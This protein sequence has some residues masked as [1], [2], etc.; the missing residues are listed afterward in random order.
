[1]AQWNQTDK[2]LQTKIV[3]WGP[4]LCG[5]TTNLKQIH[6]ITDPAGE[7][8]LISL[9]TA[10]DRT[11]FFDLLPLDLGKIFGHTLKIQVYTVPG[12]VRYDAT[13][14]IVLSGAD[15][16]VFV[17]DS[18]RGRGAENRAAWENLRTNLKAIGLDPVS[19]PAIV[20]YNKQDLAGCLTPREVEACLQSGRE[21]IIASALQGRGVLETFQCAILE[22]LKRLAT[23]SGRRRADDME[24]LENQ[25][26]RVFERYARSAEALAGSRVAPVITE[27]PVYEEAEPASAA[28]ALPTAA[29][30]PSV[31]P[32]P[33]VPSGYDDAPA[34]AP[35]PVPVPVPVPDHDA[36]PGPAPAT[37]PPPASTRRSG[38]VA[39]TTPTLLAPPAPWA[40]FAPEA[41][42]PVEPSD[43]SAR[44]LQGAPP[45]SPTTIHFLE[46]GAGED[47]LVRSLRATL[48]IAE[49]FGEMRE[50]KNRLARRIG[51][52]ESLQ[53]L[54]RE[55][56][57][58]RD[59]AS[60]LGGLVD[61]AV[62]I[63][64]ARAASILFRP[65]EGEPLRLEVA[66]GIENDPL[67]GVE[68][69][70]SHADEILNRGEAILLEVLP[71]PGGAITIETGPLRSALA[72]PLQPALR[73]AGL[74][75]AYAE[76][77]FTADDLRFLGL[78]AAHAAVC[79]DNAV[80]TERQTRYNDQLEAEV[81]ARTAELER[82]NEDLRE[83]DRMK[84][85]FLSSVSHEMKTPLTGILTGTE[86]LLSLRGDDESREFLSMVKIEALRLNDLVDR[87][88]RF[89]VLRRRAS[90][91]VPARVESFDLVS[92]TVM[93]LIDK[94]AMA[95]VEISMDLPQGM[96]V[97]EVE[98]DA[99]ALALRE[100]LDN[101]VKFSPRGGLVQVEAREKLIR[102]S[103][104]PRDEGSRYLVISIRDRGPGIATTDQTRIFEQFEQLGDLLTGKPEGLGLGLSIAREITRRQGGDLRVHSEPGA[105]S[106]FRIYIPVAEPFATGDVPAGTL[107]TAS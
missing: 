53:A 93:E 10:S 54:A 94:A 80:M 49:Q 82:A 52:L 8:R 7:N 104:S 40:V 18:Q 39:G 75:I 29:Q 42:A 71:V 20:Q 61:A 98:R 19:V 45:T 69:T 66:R 34:P 99:M 68:G 12:Q 64:V 28:P 33:S 23:I 96:P 4:A 87:I 50:V 92:K 70:D 73:P 106:D 105:G 37:L 84:D 44:A 79:L 65:S 58:R 88:L 15:A 21:G 59:S 25:V 57:M 78:L 30:T 97:I 41:A 101:A 1:M 51:E 81:R 27:V 107:E 32:A 47:L 6:A 60:I 46:D 86:L 17:A 85:R 95:E 102:K 43:P 9:N 72:V 26:G 55:M 56:S 103:A 36:A 48:G 22:M 63:P 2:T 5:K 100:V 11:L 76:E 62:S 89:Q 35:A 14:R 77:P 67:A 74:L 3:Y 24:T 31:S 16:V 90:D 13:R 91:G 83:L 38:P